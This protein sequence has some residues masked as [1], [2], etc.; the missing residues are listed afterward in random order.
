[1]AGDG[2]GENLLGI[3]ATPGIG[4]VVFDA[5]AAL[6]DLTLDGIVATIDADAVPDAVVLNPHDWA[7]MLKHKAAGSGV[8]L[9]SDGMFSDPPTSAWGLPAV[10]S[11]VM[12]A[13]TALV[14]AF[15]TCSRLF[16]RES[17]NTESRTPTRTTLFETW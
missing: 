11:K 12:P 16:I 3:L 7:G 17:V 10:L 8:R 2:I 5:A 13:G 9:D 14:G 4:S 1:M 15:G 6:S